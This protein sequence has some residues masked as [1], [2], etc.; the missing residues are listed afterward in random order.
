MTPSSSTR[1]HVRSL[2]KALFDRDLVAVTHLGAQM[3]WKAQQTLD[4]NAEELFQ[5]SLADC[6]HFMAKDSQ[7]AWESFV[8]QSLQT[9]TTQGYSLL[10][11]TGLGQIVD[12][13]DEFLLIA[14]RAGV[15]NNFRTPEGNTIAH[16]ALT[17]MPK[18][19]HTATLI[20][21]GVDLNSQNHE[22]QTVLHQLWEIGPSDS[23]LADHWVITTELL[24]C[25]GANPSLA[26]RDGVTPLDLLEHHCHS[27]PLLN[28]KQRQTLSH[29][30]NAALQE[31]EP[32][33]PEEP[34]P[35][36]RKPGMR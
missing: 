25:N 6:F 3:D 8:T 34:T 4:Q 24:L 29:A 27:N 21:E 11:D 12:E 10:G 9:L 17:P 19:D 18:E 36:H 31:L 16:L 35:R 20:S 32:P 2:Q 1:H 28:M 5:Y 7:G 15:L 23:A 33:D 26:D 30:L 22:G 14:L 13:N